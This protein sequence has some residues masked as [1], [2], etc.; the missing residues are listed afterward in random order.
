MAVAAGPEALAGADCDLRLTGEH[1][2]ECE[3]ALPSVRLGDRR[4]DE[5]RSLRPLDTPADPREAV[6]QGV[7]TPAVDIVDLHG[8]VGRLAQ[9]RD[10]RDLDRLEGAVVEVRLQ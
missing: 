5:H 7:A 3:R 8:V 10:R 1:G 6:A 4:P 9:G 2:R